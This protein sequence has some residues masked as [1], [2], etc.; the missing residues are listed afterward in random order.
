MPKKI[1]IVDDNK[2]VR[3]LLSINLRKENF[4]VLEAENGVE[5]LEVV[6]EQL[7]DL[8]ISDIIM[9]QMDGFEFCK[10]V[11][12]TS[13]VPMVPFMFLTSIDQVATE[14]RGLRTGADDYLIKSN[15]KKEELVG[16]VQA[17]LNKANEYK[18]AE[19]EIQDGLYG[20][21]SDLSLI[22]VLQL[23]I[24]NKKTGILTIT[25]DGEKAELYFDDGKML[26][27]EYKKFVGEEAVYNL[28][29]WKEG[30]FRF[31]R[32]DVNVSPTIHTVTMNLLME[33][34]RITDEQKTR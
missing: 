20:K 13:K 10:Q 28:G 2:T 33:Y 14:L 31:E 22:D 30:V 27:A 34:C 25:R 8:V 16:K 23:L 18:Q 6:N 11:R 21:F 29:E 9:P 32:T 12:T 3:T 4:E 26:H 24:M 7:P 19:Q 5:G 15:I 1:L 17:M